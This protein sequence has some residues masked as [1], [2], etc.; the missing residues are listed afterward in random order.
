MRRTLKPLVRLLLL[1]LLLLLVELIR[2]LPLPSRP[3]ICMQ[4]GTS[5][6]D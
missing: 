4:C 1:L 3:W 2:Q 6:I 5:E